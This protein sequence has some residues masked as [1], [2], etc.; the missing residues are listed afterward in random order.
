MTIEKRIQDLLAIKNFM[1]GD[2]EIWEVAKERASYENGWFTKEFVDL[3]ILSICND[4]LEKT[5]LVEFC[6]SYP[7][8][9]QLSTKQVGILMAGNI[10]LVGFHDFICG[11]LSGHQLLLKLS[12]K[13]SILFKA[14]LQELI[15]IEPAYTSRVSCSEMLRKCD[16][17]MATGSTNSINVFQEYFGKYPSIVRDNKT[18]VAILSGQETIE[19]L[20]ELSK[21]IHYYFGLGCRNVTKIF[22]PKNYDFETFLGITKSYNYFADH[23]KYKNN[24]DYNLAICLLNKV[25]YMT[26]GHLLLLENES[27][28]SPIACLHYEFYDDAEKLYTDLKSDSKIQCIVGSKGLKFGAAQHPSLFDFADGIDTMQ[29]LT[30]L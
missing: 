23:H 12:S 7:V 25:Y 28:F 29:F 9:D 3:A 6:Q 21:D 4:Y 11:I 15:R 22:V 24:Y 10:P 19:E 13:D 16:A 1:Q 18:S 17:Y 30:G 5:A 26:D 20:Q 27:I 8:L 2:S 14:I